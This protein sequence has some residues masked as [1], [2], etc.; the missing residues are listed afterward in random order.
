MAVPAAAGDATAVSQH[1][2]Y[3]YE[4]KSVSPKN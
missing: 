1:L 3:Q 2:T 4:T